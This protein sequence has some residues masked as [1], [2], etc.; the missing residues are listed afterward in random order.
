MSLQNLAA[1]LHARKGT[2]STCA[3]KGT[4]P[5]NP[6]PERVA[7]AELSFQ[8]LP[9][10]KRF[11]LPLRVSEASHQRCEIAQDRHFAAD[12][13]GVELHF[14]SDGE[15]NRHVQTP[16]PRTR[17]GNQ[18]PLSWPCTENPKALF[19]NSAPRP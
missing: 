8:K 2:A 9:A 19:S 14:F 13:N 7:T 3:P 1:Q 15:S 16:A 10:K 6:R 5:T 11:S 17:T 18:E 12:R 4:Q